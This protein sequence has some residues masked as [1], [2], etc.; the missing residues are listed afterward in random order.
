M[1]TIS[2]KQFI[3][4]RR[5]LK[6]KFKLMQIEVLDKNIKRLNENGYTLNNLNL[7]TIWLTK[8]LQIIC[9]ADIIPYEEN[10]LKLTSYLIYLSYLYG[11]DLLSLNQNELGVV[12]S[13]LKIPQVIKKNLYNL[14]MN[15]EGNYFSDCIETMNNSLYR[16]NTKEDRRILIKKCQPKK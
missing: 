15:N 13:K 11:I 7:E 8:S 1:D 2:L 5:L 14:M 12:L 16:E 9:T 3:E 6:T 10:H 4:E